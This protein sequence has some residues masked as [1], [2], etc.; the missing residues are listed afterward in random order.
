MVFTVDGSEYGPI[1]LGI[2]YNVLTQE[3]IDEF[4]DFDVAKFFEESGAK[5]GML[6]TN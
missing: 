3:Q 4:K 1:D 2:D 5:E 6:Y